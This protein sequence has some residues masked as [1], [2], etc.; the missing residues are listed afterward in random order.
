MANDPKD[1]IDQE[2]GAEELGQDSTI[3]NSDIGDDWGDAF[4]AEDFMFTPD[5][6][7]SSEF[8]LDD[9]SFE[10]EVSPA[11][12]QAAT[13]TGILQLDP[14]SASPGL[15]IPLL[16]S[17]ITNAKNKF[18][19][20]Y[21]SAPIYLRVIIACAPVLLIAGLFLLLRGEP[22]IAAIQ[23]EKPGE[24]SLVDPAKGKGSQAEE[25][26]V[27]VTEE[28]KP[29]V[30]EELD[31]SKAPAPEVRKKW[32]LPTFIISTK[33]NEGAGKQHSLIAVDITLVLSLKENET[34]P[35]AKEAFARELIYNFYT[36]R[37]FYELQRFSL[38]RGEMNRKLKAWVVKQWPGIPLVSVNFDRYQIL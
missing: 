14:S 30:Y 22:D 38:A 20:H 28:R 9:D 34:L 3:F 27:A 6:E 31:L 5:E 8:F 4:Q 19:I 12:D 16:L 35:Y 15:S 1:P 25:D 32:E 23:E 24:Q 33:P 21:L 17:K 10:E 29:G 13:Q 36:N 11:A 18:L 37:P 7:A 26:Q 2:E